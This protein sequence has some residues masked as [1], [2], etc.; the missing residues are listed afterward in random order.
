MSFGSWRLVGVKMAT[1]DLFFTTMGFYP[2]FPSVRGLAGTMLRRYRRKLPATSGYYSSSTYHD[3]LSSV[4][5]LEGCS[6]Y[7]RSRVSASEIR[8][9]GAMHRNLIKVLAFRIVVI[10]STS[11]SN[12]FTYHS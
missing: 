6:G 4:W 12:T 1:N 11:T 8:R 2:L 5:E 3:P 7:D 10:I 9:H